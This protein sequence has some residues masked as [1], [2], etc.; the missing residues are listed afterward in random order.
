METTK[1][2]K[3]KHMSLGRAQCDSQ[4]GIG[5]AAVWMWGTGL[6]LK[7]HLTGT[8]LHGL[9]LHLAKETGLAQGRMEKCLVSPGEWGS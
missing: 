2:G 9:P 7:L 5:S 4:V 1:T 8:V 3:N 6:L